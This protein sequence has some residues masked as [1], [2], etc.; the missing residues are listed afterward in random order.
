[1]FHSGRTRKN[2]ED[3]VWSPE[4]QKRC[5]KW[6][7]K[8]AHY[9]DYDASYAWRPTAWLP[10]GWVWHLAHDGR[11]RRMQTSKIDAFNKT[12]TT[13]SIGPVVLQYADNR[14][15]HDSSKTV[16]K[17]KADDDDDDEGS[18]S[19]S[20]SRSGGE[21]D[22]EKSGESKSGGGG[23]SEEEEKSEEK[24]KPAMAPVEVRR[25]ALGIP[26]TQQDIDD[27]AAMLRQI[28]AQLR[29]KSSSSSALLAGSLFIS[30]S[31]GSEDGGD[32]MQLVGCDWCDANKAKALAAGMALMTIPE[33]LVSKLDVFS[34]LVTAVKRADLI[35]AL[36]GRPVGKVKGGRC[37]TVFAPRNT[38]QLSSIK[39]DAVLKAT[40]LDHVAVGCFNFEKL[41]N[42][43]K[44]TMMSGKT[45][46]VL[47]NAD[48]TSM[49]IGS[50]QIIGR[51][52]E[53]EMKAS[54]GVI[55]Q[56]DSL[57]GKRKPMYPMHTY[58]KWQEQQLAG[59]QFICG[60]ATL[61]D[62]PGSSSALLKSAATSSEDGGSGAL[63]LSAEEAT[64]VANEFAEKPL[65]NEA[66]IK[67]SIKN[68]VETGAP[69]ELEFEHK[70]VAN[71]AG[72]Q[73]K[74]TIEP[75]LVQHVHVTLSGK[76]HTL[77]SGNRAYYFDL[78]VA[79]SSV[80]HGPN[81]GLRAVAPKALKIEFNKST[82]Q[83]APKM[84]SK[85][86]DLLV[87]GQVH[88]ASIAA[89]QKQLDKLICEALTA[90]DA[91]AAAAAPAVG[92]GSSAAKK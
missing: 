21:S 72:L 89:T 48:R 65:V 24:A 4:D 91:A 76:T 73:I 25:D 16:Q 20:E 50:A 42:T 33:V 6:H 47:V 43:Q 32:S 58:E 17:A 80:E 69:V 13:V 30:G 35:G 88:E 90:P 81:A 1:M 34:E 12:L 61:N 68:A 36:S 3:Y 51:K 44:I 57:I 37:W 31:I 10:R 7:K 22:A 85:Q 14:H 56:I 60:N 23:E 27:E 5:R 62:T 45:H 52:Q 54:N 53:A 39:N 67:A 49:T 26:I 59:M 11:Y 92:G 70:Y 28:G 83:Y 84:I 19:G 40:L 78:G 55:Y 18:A 2:P 86:L 66:G 29:M 8:F 63:R 79:P 15:R 75:A 9:H 74:G 71:M 64:N 41:V 82:M 46:I 38:G 77:P 87:E